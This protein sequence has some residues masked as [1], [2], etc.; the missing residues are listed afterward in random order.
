M[1]IPYAKKKFKFD[2]SD[3]N[4]CFYTNL[5]IGSIVNILLPFWQIFAKPP[6]GALKH[7]VLTKDL[8]TI[9]LFWQ[10]LFITS[11]QNLS[12]IYALILIFTSVIKSK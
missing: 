3:C 2:T 1:H 4:V 5:N 6:V 10:K 7:F 9:T 11:F 12:N 8:K